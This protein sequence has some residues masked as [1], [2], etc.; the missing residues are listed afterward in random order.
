[1]DQQRR[2]RQQQPPASYQFRRPLE[3]VTGGCLEIL[4]MFT[5]LQLWKIMDI[6]VIPQFSAMVER[7]EKAVVFTTMDQFKTLVT[8]NLKVNCCTHV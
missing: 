8:V 7:E 6:E 4:V 2:R 1:M 5:T 3:V